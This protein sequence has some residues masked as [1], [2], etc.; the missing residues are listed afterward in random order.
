MIDHRTFAHFGP[1]IRVFGQNELETEKNHD[2]VAEESEF[3]LASPL[4][5]STF[6][7]RRRT[8]KTRLD[9]LQSLH[10]VF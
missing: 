3:E 5:V 9:S 7:S 2:C 10:R 6:T 1:Q 4:F 8:G